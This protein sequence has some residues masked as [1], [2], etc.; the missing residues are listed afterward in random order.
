MLVTL[1]KIDVLK[2]LLHAVTCDGRPFSSIED[3][4]FRIGFK[5]VM[6]RLPVKYNRRNIVNLVEDAANYIR[7]KLK[8]MLQNNLVS[9]KADGVTKFSRSFL[10][11][12]V[13]VS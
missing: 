6:D 13:Q 9:I 4:L 3:G 2:G 11:L 12:N 7:T 5:P 8:S 10:G 1:S